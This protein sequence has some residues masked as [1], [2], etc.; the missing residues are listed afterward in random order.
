[1]RGGPKIQNCASA[2]LGH[3]SSAAISA[4]TTPKER[5]RLSIIRPNPDAAQPMSALSFAP[6]LPPWQGDRVSATFR[7]PFRFRLPFSELWSMRIE[8]PYS[9]LLRADGLA[10]S[11]GQCPL[12]AD[13]AVLAP[14]NLCGQADHVIAYISHILDKA[15][16]NAANVGK[17]VL[18]HAPLEP[19]DTARMLERFRTAFPGAVLMP[20]GT[21]FFY[22][23]GM[24]LEVDMHAAEPCGPLASA[25]DDVCGLRIQAVDGG[26]LVWVSLELL[27]DRDGGR[28]QARVAD[29]VHDAL[30]A[31]AG[32]SAAE[33]LADHWFVGGDEAGPALARLREAGLVTDPRGP[34]SA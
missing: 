3:Q 9:L 31:T 4:A 11:C 26:E 21:P 15:Q 13:G 16:F 32:L 20:I 28:G 7:A 14:D 19:R 22:Y 6:I 18:Y 29:E 8:H 10:W 12:A 17:L 27:A 25:S 30:R 34:P 23:R 2:A 24:R 33:L 5:K 1:V